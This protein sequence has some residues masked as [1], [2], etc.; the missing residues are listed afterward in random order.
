MEQ[1]RYSFPKSNHLR[2]RGEYLRLLNAENRFSCR[3]FLVVWSKGATENPR[4]GITVSKKIGSA[5]V[6]NRIKR[7]VRELFRVNKIEIPPVD[8]NVIA[9]SG[10]NE[11]DYQQISFELLKAFKKIGSN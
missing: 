11:M 3:S 4:I 2:K 1:G 5:V 9:R 7:Y 8:I 10:A 6:R